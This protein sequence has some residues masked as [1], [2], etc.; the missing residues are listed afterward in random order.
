[1]FVLQVCF[2]DFPFHRDNF[3]PDQRFSSY[4]KVGDLVR[5]F[6]EFDLHDTCWNWSEPDWLV[7]SLKDLQF[8]NLSRLLDGEECILLSDP[9][10]VS[11]IQNCP[12]QVQIR[13]FQQAPTLMGVCFQI[14]L[15]GSFLLKL[16]PLTWLYHQFLFESQNH[17]FLLQAQL[18][19]FNVILGSPKQISL[20]LSVTGGP[21]VHNCFLTNDS[22]CSWICFK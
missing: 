6:G 14:I 21:I 2:F 16:H 1:M 11:L 3:L 13:N 22:P 12:K 18:K 5:F 4:I 7:D 10:Y 8:H 17:N 20:L 9:N 19:L 15:H